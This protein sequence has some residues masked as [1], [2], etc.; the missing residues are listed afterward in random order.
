MLGRFLERKKCMGP[1]LLFI[2]KGPHFGAGDPDKGNF[3][4]RKKRGKND[5]DDEE[6]DLDEVLDHLNSRRA[7]AHRMFWFIGKISVSYSESDLINPA[8]IA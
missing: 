5:A 8:L 7:G 1:Y 4:T 3:G 6:Q 2:V